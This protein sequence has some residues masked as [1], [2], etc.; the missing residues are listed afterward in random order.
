MKSLENSLYSFKNKN[1]AEY[2]QLLETIKNKDVYMV[3]NS[4]D[5]NN[6]LIVPI[7]GTDDFAIVIST[8]KELDEM[9]KE[10]MKIDSIKISGD[11]LRKLLDKLFFKGVFNVII[12]FKHNGKPK[13]VL[14]NTPELS[15]NKYVVKENKKIIKLLI[16][17]LRTKEYFN[18][19]CHHTVTP[20]EIV[21]C[22]V[23][24]YMLSE[25]TKKYINIF[26]NESVLEKYLNSKKDIDLLIYPNMFDENN[27]RCK[28]E[29]YPISTISNDVLY[30]SMNILRNKIDFIVIHTTEGKIKVDLNTFVN[31]ILAIG[32][33]PIDLS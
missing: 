15:E 11:D 16:K 25:G 13:S 33:N 18:Y 2:E 22:I 10:D 8:E 31:L 3:V 24:H 12:N 26:E 14:C 20:S 4:I 30:H 21:F 28:P 6:P 17:V 9:F 27:K 29:N 1:K 5:I 23:R 19:I 7:E 32:F